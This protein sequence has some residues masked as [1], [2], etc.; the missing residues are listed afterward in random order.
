MSLVCLVVVKYFMV[1]EHACF[2]IVHFGLCFTI[3]Q[4]SGYILNVCKAEYLSTM[5]SKSWTHIDVCCLQYHTNEIILSVLINSR[6]VVFRNFHPSFLSMN[7]LIMIQTV[8]QS[9]YLLTREGFRLSSQEASSSFGD[10]RLL[11]EKFIDNPR[12]IEIQ[13]ID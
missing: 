3:L 7:K 12:H 11:V 5:I 10:D 4:V 6:R 2:F 1:A 8:S 13:V 9:S